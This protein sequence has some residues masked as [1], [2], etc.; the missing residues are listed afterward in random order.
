MIIDPASP[1]QQDALFTQHDLIEV[2]SLK[3]YHT[4]VY[5]VEYSTAR[6]ERPHDPFC[7]EVTIGSPFESMSMRRSRCQMLL[8]TERDGTGRDGFDLKYLT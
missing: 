2:P 7:V 3:E 4:L 8:G 1:L 5:S 6:F